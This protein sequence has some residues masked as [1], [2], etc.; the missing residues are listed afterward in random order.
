MKQQLKRIVAAQITDL[1]ID[2]TEYKSIVYHF[3][4]R[5]NKDDP[6][7]IEYF[8]IMNNYKQLMRKTQS[9]LKKL[10]ALQNEI[11]SMV[12][13]MTSESEVSVTVSNVKTAF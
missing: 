2:L 3:E 9:K 5:S 8:K 12:G 13:Y 4:R 11:K 6:S 1:Q 10:V 7:T